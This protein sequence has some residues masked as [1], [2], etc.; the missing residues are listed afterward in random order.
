MKDTI[1]WLQ[2]QPRKKSDGNALYSSITDISEWVKR[3][4]KL[5]TGEQARLYFQLLVEVNQLELSVKERLN[6]LEKMHLPVLLLIDKLAKRY[7]GSALPLTED[8]AKFVEIVNTFWSEMAKGYKIIIDDLSEHS[9]FTTFI[10]Q[11]D[12]SCALY[13]VLYYLSGQLYSNYMLYA[14]C[15]ENVWRDIHQ[16]YRFA[17][18]RNLTNKK[19]THHLIADLTIAESYKKIL[20]FSL[21]NPYHLSVNEM[22]VTWH[23][24]DKWAKFAQL[25]LHTIKVIKNNYTFLIQPFSDKAPFQ[26]NYVSQPINSV[27]QLDLSSDSIWGLDTK[28][29]L[30]QLAVKDKYPD[31]SHYFLE[32]IIK[33][34]AGISHRKMVRKELIEPVVIAV[35]VSCIS[36]FLAEIDI[37]PKILKI[38]NKPFKELEITTSEHAFYQA[39]LVDESSKGLRL[40]LNHQ[41]EKPIAPN[42]GEVIAVKH[43]NGSFQIGYIRWMRESTV[44]DIE[45]GFEHLCAMA[46]PVQLTKYHK[47]H[48]QDEPLEKQNVLGS[49]VFPGTKEH[50]FKPILF[51][52]TF[53]EK[54]YN[55]RTDHLVMT[56]KTG[57][58]NIKLIQ[59]V[60]EIH[61]YSLYL[62][63]K[64]NESDR[65]VNTDDIKTDQFDSIWEKI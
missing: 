24:L 14:K 31:I 47:L 53:V 1:L 51:T 40:K 26:N 2:L 44:G 56:H 39:Y 34:W 62:F 48:Q 59:K 30:K 7:A 63:D 33:S 25:N 45:F 54:F 32:R 52:H 57:S 5:K 41:S 11:K 21:V 17:S 35:G 42:I 60:N 4:Y 37:S 6:F 18:K 46:E 50:Q 13:Y 49:F 16:V 43:E 61:D 19:I 10:K 12:L 9:F 20:L 64:M 8:K 58:M 29:L 28:K 38:E 15:S 23:N 36:Q 27:D 65:E 22:E 3:N 55:T